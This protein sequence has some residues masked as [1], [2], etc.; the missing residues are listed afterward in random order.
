MV[1]PMLRKKNRKNTKN[2]TANDVPLNNKLFGDTPSMEGQDLENIFKNGLAKI[3]SIQ[4][5]Y[6]CEQA[7]ELSPAIKPALASGAKKGIVEKVAQD[8][9]TTGVIA[10]ILGTI[11]LYSLS[12]LW[13]S[14]GFEEMTT[15]QVSGEIFLNPGQMDTF[16]GFIVS[17]MTHFMVGSAGGVLLAYFMRFSGYDFY[18]L[19]GLALAGFMLLV[20][21]GLLVNIMNIAGD[22]RKD[23]T[24]ALFHSINYTAYGLVVSYVIFKLASSRSNGDGS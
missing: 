13:S 24:E 16:P 20:G 14:L 12:I 3:E 19:K 18:W 11:V 1:F 21:M 9:F 10:G 4:V 22:M 15:L 23:A 6:D 5:R 8:T 2:E 7:A 17:F